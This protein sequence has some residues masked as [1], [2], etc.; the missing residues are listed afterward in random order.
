MLNKICLSFLLKAGNSNIL[1]VIVK[2]GLG[3]NKNTATKN[4]NRSSN[5]VLMSYEN[6]RLKN[7]N[8]NCNSVLQSNGKKKNENT[9]WN[10]IF[11]VVG[12]RKTEN[13]KRK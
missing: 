3:S 6:V 5:S 12:K 1:P 13:G 7:G 8:D 2:Y 9:S 10:S 11:N 4:E